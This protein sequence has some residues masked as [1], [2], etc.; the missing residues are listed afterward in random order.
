MTIESQQMNVQKPQVTC[1]SVSL[2]SS[3]RYEIQP[4][5]SIHLTV[6]RCWEMVQSINYLTVRG[7]LAS[8]VGWLQLEVSMS[9]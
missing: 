7:E 1:K 9:E 2:K 5:D 6:T 4:L 3:L 8:L